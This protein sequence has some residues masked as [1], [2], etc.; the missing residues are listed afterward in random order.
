MKIYIVMLKQF[1]IQRREIL[2]ELRDGNKAKAFRNLV[3]YSVALSVINGGVMTGIDYMRGNTDME[4]TDNMAEAFLRNYGTGEYLNSKALQSVRDAQED[5]NAVG[6]AVAAAGYA[7]AIMQQMIAP[8]ALNKAISLSEDLTR[9]GDPE[10][11]Y[12]IVR[13]A[14]IVGSLIE[15]WFLGGIERDEERRADRE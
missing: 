4:I 3:R 13:T 2:D 8:V 14:P 12:R 11:D 7:G 6:Q 1:D 15:R 5:G 9:A 10:G